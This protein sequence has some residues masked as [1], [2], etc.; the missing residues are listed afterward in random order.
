MIQHLGKVKKVI[1]FNERKISFVGTHFKDAKVEMSKLLYK[2]SASYTLVNDLNLGDEVI[3]TNMDKGTK[4]EVKRSIKEGEVKIEKVSLEIFI[5][6]YN[7]FAETKGLNIISH[8]MM[9]F[10]PEIIIRGAYLSNSLAAAHAYTYSKELGIVRLLYS[11]TEPRMY[12]D[13][14]LRSK[15][16]RTNRFLHYDDMRYFKKQGYTTYDFGGFAKDT[17]DKGLLGI[18]KFKSGF[19]G[20]ITRLTNY[21]L[22][23]QGFNLVIESYHW[24]RSK[25]KFNETNL[26]RK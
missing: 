1:W 10:D 8:D 19:G 24:V 22:W 26:K 15:I 13:A 20:E 14:E 17:Q 2:K 23:F 25:L 16:G 7:R 12:E 3:L 11:V 6:V 4:Y 21:Q 18:N 9:N 5:E